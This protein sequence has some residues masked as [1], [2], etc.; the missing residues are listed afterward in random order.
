MDA[1]RRSAVLTGVFLLLGTVVGVI[2]LGVV[3]EPLNSATDSLT[4]YGESE[5]RVAAAS[6][7][8]LFMGV[9]L[10]GMAIA[11]YPVL[12]KFSPGAAIAYIGARLLEGVIY[13]IL[14][15]SMLALA[16]LGRDY[17]AAGSPSDSYFQVAGGL[18]HAV[19]DWAGH[20]IL[21]VAI[22]PLGAVILYTVFYRFGLVPRW[23]SVWGLVG[24]VLYWVAGF[25]V[26]FDLIA[27]LESVH[28]ILQ[29]PL[30]LQE[31][32]LAIWLMAKGF[33]ASAL[34][35]VAPASGPGASS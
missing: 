29:A 3:L 30:G 34:A 7:V 22:F 33:N 1:D 15:L 23:L 2:G 20:G 5:T 32:V 13:I 28:I 24:A 6:L 8:E 21:D 12:R 16:G 27:P 14:V 26:M 4:V 18:L 10:V 11:V 17:I 25:L 35:S 31:V 9:V 19:P